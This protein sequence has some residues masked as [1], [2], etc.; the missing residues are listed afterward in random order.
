MRSE[1]T[2]FSFVF[3]FVVVVSTR[4][5]IAVINMLSVFISSILS[6]SINFCDN[7]MEMKSKGNAP[8]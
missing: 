3:F 2:H 5:L 6:F 1:F 4:L 8:L 7:A